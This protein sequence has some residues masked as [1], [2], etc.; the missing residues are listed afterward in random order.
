MKYRFSIVIPHRNSLDL[1][2]RCVESIPCRQDIQVIV[3]DDNSDIPETDWQ[4]FREDY[5]GA[6]VY[7]TLEGRGAGYARNVGI[8]KAAGEWIIFADA[9]DF[10]YEGAFDFFDKWADSEYDVLYFACDSRDSV[11]LEQIK[12]RMPSIRENIK[13]G[14]ID[15]LRYRSI[16]PWGKMIRRTLLLDSGLKFEEVEVSNDVMFSIRLGV[17]TKSPGIIQSD[18]LYCCTASEGSLYHGT[19]VKRTITRVKIAKRAND[20]LHQQGLDRFRIPIC[21]V[22][23]FLPRHPLLFIWG[24]WMFRYKGHAGEYMKDMV[25]YVKRYLRA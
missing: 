8:D 11:I 21:H 20:Y 12:D 10:F 7:L 22:S 4:V 3:V 14:N 5:P 2:R 19:S 17:E 13:T 24:L 25:K 1:L 18:P 15:G 16:V 23:N 9:D 6:E